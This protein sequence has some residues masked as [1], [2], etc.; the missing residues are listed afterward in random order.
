MTVRERFLAMG[1]LG[2]VTLAGVALIVSQFVVSPLRERGRSIDKLKS[3]IA[4][5]RDRIAT[6]LAEKPKMELW[7][8]Q[9]LPADIGLARLE[10][11]KYLRELFRQSGFEGSTVSVTPRPLETRTGLLTLPGKKDPAF[12]PMTFAVQ[13]QGDATLPGPQLGDLVDFLERFYRTPL[14]HQIKSM[15]ISISKP[16]SCTKRIRAISCFRAWI[17]NWPVWI[18]SRRF[19]MARLLWRWCP[20]R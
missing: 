19:A 10:Y 17:A 5:K 3:D 9:S 8:K 15:T 18:W 6:I 16:S 11:E 12:T 20:G 13:A 2:F 4:E 7:R 1:V 14:L